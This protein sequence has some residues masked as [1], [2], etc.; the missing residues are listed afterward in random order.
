MKLKNKP[1]SE[2]SEELADILSLYYPNEYGDCDSREIKKYLSEGDGIVGID[3]DKVMIIPRE[4][5][6]DIWLCKTCYFPR[7]VNPQI[8]DGVCISCKRKDEFSLDDFSLVSKD[9][10]SGKNKDMLKQN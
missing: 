4:I 1:F 7:L 10:L 2:I 9:S 8:D 6:G 5:E 3:A